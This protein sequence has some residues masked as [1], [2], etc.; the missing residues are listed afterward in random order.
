M[1]YTLASRF[2]IKKSG[3]KDLLYIF[4]AGSIFY[5]ALH[6]YLNMEDRSGMIG[7]V[8]EYLYPMMIVDGLTAYTL[9]KVMPVQSADSE[10]QS[11]NKQDESVQSPT[12]EQK[13]L[14]LQ[15]MQEQSK[16]QLKMRENMANELVT[17]N[18]NSNQ[19]PVT[20]QLP[21][22]PATG[23]A[24]VSEKSKPTIFSKSDSV[25]E[26]ED[27]DSTS[28]DLEETEKAENPKDE[29][30]KSEDKQNI[31]VTKKNENKKNES[32]DTEIPI[33]NVSK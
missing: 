11:E 29:T 33:Y 15:K 23:S 4:L 10:D 3:D 31:R 32:N 21:S 2:L 14:I 30:K 16:Q 6:W 7:T 20:N 5:I 8:R 1:F 19:K 25:K 12:E 13:R 28:D 9:L 24:Q 27:K 22:T 17:Q 18:N 26:E